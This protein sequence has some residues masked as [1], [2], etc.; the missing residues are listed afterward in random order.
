MS[1]VMEQMAE[2]LRRASDDDEM[3]QCYAHDEDRIGFRTC[4]SAY[5]YKPH[6][7]GCWVL[8][9]RAALAA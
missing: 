6:K 7:D 3:R 2:A 8:E 5:S 4:C 9:C 1:N